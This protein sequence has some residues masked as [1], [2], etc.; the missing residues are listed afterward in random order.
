L[1]SQ[2]AMLT[3]SSAEK[4][5]SNNQTWQNMKKPKNILVLCTV[6]AGVDILLQ[7]YEN[8]IHIL[9]WLSLDPTK[10]GP[11]SISG[12]VDCSQ[13]SK[14]LGINHS[15]VDSYSLNSNSDREKIS[16]INPDLVLVL[17]W[18]RLVPDWLIGIPEFGVLG[19]HGSPHGI[20]KGRGR[21]P[22]TWS[23]IFAE[24]EFELSLFKIDSGVDSGAVLDR[25]K[26]KI[27]KEDDIRTSYF[28]SCLAAAEMITDLLTNPEKDF[29]GE[30]Q[31]AEFRYYPARE[32]EDGFVDWNLS[33][34]QIVRHCRALT[35]PYPGLRF[36]DEE[37]I[38]T[39]WNCF[40]FDET[41]TGEPGRISA[42][43]NSG[44]FLVECKDGR[45][46]IRKW[47]SDPKS[48]IPKSGNVLSGVEWS[49]T[50]RKIVKRHEQKNPEQKLT[51]DFYEL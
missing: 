37:A 12:F 21:S 33:K 8:D 16:A 26:W 7:L 48:W 20:E 43:F 10:H 38:V 47:S 1:E 4:N 35:Y 25:R 30:L 3:A 17:G 19:T 36:C 44:D 31:S 23:I 11:D 39:I 34:D 18:Q 6:E 14:E 46:L 5:L 2:Q 13:I 15:F 45:I 24:E 41:T 40:Q 9:H 42:C 28:R 32:P 51:D 27:R 49:E 22:Q 29:E 50:M